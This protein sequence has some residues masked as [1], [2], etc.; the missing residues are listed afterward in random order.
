MLFRSI[1]AANPWIL[2]QLVTGEEFCTHTTAR[3]GRVQLYACSRSSAFQVNY[4]MVDEPRIEAWVRSFVGALGLTGQVSFDF[5]RSADGEVYAIECNPRTHS[6]VTMFDD[7]E[8]LTRAYLEDDVDPVLPRSTSRPTYWIYHEAWR[9]LA[10]PGRLARLRTVARG[11]DAIFS[12]SDPLP[13]LLEHH[14][15]VP[16]LLLSSLRRG[17]SWIRIDFN[18]G[19]L[20]EADGD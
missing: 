8:A 1:T 14:L 13:F 12:W 11:R 15:Q 5:I 6:A 18:I 20:V 9:L 2:Q 10:E 17:R 19:K 3:Q 4:A 7:A 16:L